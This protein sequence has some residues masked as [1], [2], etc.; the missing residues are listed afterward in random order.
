MLLRIY[1]PMLALVTATQLCYAQK[2]PEIPK[3]K[4]VIEDHEKVLKFEVQEDE[5]EVSANNRL[6]YTWFSHHKIHTTRGGFEG[7]L[8]HGEFLVMNKARD[9]LQKGQF[10]YG[11]KNKVWKTWYPDGELKSITHFKKGKLHGVE[12]QFDDMGDVVSKTRYRFGKKHG[13]E[14]LF[15]E[16][17][18]EEIIKY[19]K[20]KEVGSKDKSFFKDDE[21][22]INEDDTQ[23]EDKKRKKEKRKKKKDQKKKETEEDKK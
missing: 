20:G 4:I 9:L 21:E 5:K 1:I 17:G 22:P 8:L 13:K 23:P 18:D 7:H 2:T 6:F 11:L 16:D 15:N 12:I 14:H 19:K 10:Y 3:H